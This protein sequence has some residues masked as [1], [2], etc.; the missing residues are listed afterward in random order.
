M[1]R[2]KKEPFWKTLLPDLEFEERE[3]SAMAGRLPIGLFLP[4]GEVVRTV[5]FEKFLG[6]HEVALGDAEDES[7]PRKEAGDLF[8]YYQ[9]VFVKF[10]SGKHP[11]IRY[12]G[13]RTLSQ[14]AELLGLN[15]RQIIQELYVGDLIHLV[16]SLR[17]RVYG[18][19]VSY[20]L[21]KCYCD[22]AVPISD[23]FS[24]STT[25]FRCWEKDTPPRFSLPL[26][27]PVS[28]G[29]R[30]VEEIILE[31]P[32]LKHLAKIGDR[33]KSDEIPYWRL[34]LAEINP[35]FDEDLFWS[36]EFSDQ[37]K[38]EIAFNEILKFGAE[39]SIQMD[40]SVCQRTFV[41][42]MR[43]GV[44]HES[45]YFSLL[46]APRQKGKTVEGTI[47]QIA[48]FLNIG[49]QGLKLSLDEIYALTPSRRDALVKQLSDCYE[50]QQK[51]LE[52][53]KK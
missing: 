35:G 45:F 40:C 9:E 32:K 51:E 52:K 43:P 44:D 22:L 25:I 3:M 17:R 5:E 10:F 33:L 42:K 38:I 30:R 23:W 31:P 50:R 47:D 19:I 12:L 7:E 14:T 1:S 53:S 2:T 28:I 20:K 27:A 34:L 11:A 37:R 6:H 21:Q 48:F 8:G 41:S 36:M 39:R 46:E 29:D 15:I 24:L 16:V 26:S 49:D 18:D 4:N 13:D